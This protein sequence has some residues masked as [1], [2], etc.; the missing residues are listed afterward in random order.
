MYFDR[1]GFLR[2]LLDAKYTLCLQVK[3]RLIMKAHSTLA[4]DLETEDKK[5]NSI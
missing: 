1:T 5:G 4:L 2:I 3:L